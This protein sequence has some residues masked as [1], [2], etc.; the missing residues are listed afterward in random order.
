MVC[1]S[2]LALEAICAGKVYTVA[3]TTCTSPR[4]PCVCGTTVVHFIKVCLRSRWSCS[5]RLEHEQLQDDI[6]RRQLLQ[7]QV[8]SRPQ[9]TPTRA[10]FL[11][12]QLFCPLKSKKKLYVIAL[13]REWVMPAC[14]NT[15]IYIYIYISMSRSLSVDFFPFRK[16]YDPCRNLTSHGGRYAGCIF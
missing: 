14:P 6:S 7:W 15:H 3:T 12:I 10:S 8:F 2:S 5:R 13:S 4:K 11:V 1:D 9:K 16:G